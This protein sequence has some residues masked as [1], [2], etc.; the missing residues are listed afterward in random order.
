MPETVQTAVREMAAAMSADERILV[1]M[2]GAKYALEAVKA[3]Q[4][5]QEEAQENA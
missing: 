5:K 1:F 4:A 3:E 2:Q